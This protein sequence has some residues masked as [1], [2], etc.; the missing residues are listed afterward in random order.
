MTPITARPAAAAATCPH[1]ENGHL[2]GVILEPLQITAVMAGLG[3]PI[4]GSDV[5]NRTIWYVIQ[6]YARLGSWSAYGRD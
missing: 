6:Q 3:V 4:L 1:R 2:P 5:Q